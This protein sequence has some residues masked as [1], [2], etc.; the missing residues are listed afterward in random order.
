MR[1][2]CGD[3]PCLWSAWTGSFRFQMPRDG[4]GSVVRAL[5]V[6]AE[7]WNLVPST[8]MLT[9]HHLSIGTGVVHMYTF[10][11]NIQILLQHGC[12]QETLLG[13]AGS[14]LGPC[15]MVEETELDSVQ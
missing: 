8:Q 15:L 6:L 13:T 12:N 5:A 4:V 11:Q 1:K 3:G 14:G 10:T 7:G 2:V 9:C